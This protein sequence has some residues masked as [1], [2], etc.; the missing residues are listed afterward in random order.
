MAANS[1]EK[2]RALEQCERDLDVAIERLVNLRLD[3]AGAHHDDVHP[4]TAAAAEEEGE[5]RTVD[6]HV[7]SDG[8]D[9]RTD[10]WIERFMEAMACAENWGDA[11]ARAA[12]LLKDF[13]ASVA[14]TCRAERDVALWQNGLLKKAVR[15]QH[16]LYKEKEAANR[17][18]Q[19]QLA[20][21]QERV[22]SL[23]TD[24]Y[25]LSMHLRNAQPQPQGGSIT[26]RFHP[27]VF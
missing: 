14:T 6:V 19:R 26:G 2:A 13:D 11:R 16:R 3:A 27:E 5:Q 12:G 15:V 18:L 1:A 8:S 9:D 17:E 7:P 21:C 22:R 4:A 23:E 25:A 24:N 10:Q 20:G